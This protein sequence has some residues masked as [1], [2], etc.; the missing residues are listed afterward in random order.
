MEI[1]KSNK[2]KLNLLYRDEVFKIVGAAYAVYNELGNGFLESVY[3]EALKI[4][5]SNN[6]IPFRSQVS[7]QIRYKGHILNKEFCADLILYTRLFRI[8][9]YIS[10]ILY[11]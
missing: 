10:F 2:G 11:R 3:E 4:E 8:K 5:L 6:N 7:L 1:Q 9:G